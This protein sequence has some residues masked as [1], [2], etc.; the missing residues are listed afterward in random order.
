M[1][2]LETAIKHA[3]VFTIKYF[4]DPNLLP[5]LP[6][7]IKNSEEELTAIVKNTT[8]FY[9]MIYK[10]RKKRWAGDLTGL[11]AEE[12]HIPETRH[13]DGRT[14]RAESNYRVNAEYLRTIGIDSSKI[15]FFRITQPSDE[16]KP[17]Y[18]WTSDYFET[19]RGL[20]IEVAGKQ[21]DT[22]VILVS[23]LG[24]I[25]QNEGLI[26]D[27]NDDEGLSVRQIGTGHFGQNNAIARF[28]PDFGLYLP[29]LL[30]SDLFVKRRLNKTAK[31]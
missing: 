17:E 10:E 19:L 22:A 24:T 20:D 1:D 14:R 8:R 9:E 13:A 4:Q 15:L 28:K 26:Q 30:P 5:A 7:S 23:D 18:Y 2:A 3:N 16:P 25:N 29:Q 11:F 31:Q 21:R 12:V 6:E 27:M